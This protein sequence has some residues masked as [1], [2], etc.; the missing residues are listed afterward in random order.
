[1]S[2]LRRYGLLSVLGL[3]ALLWTLRHGGAPTPPKL[4]SPE[5]SKLLAWF[6]ALASVAVV[7]LAALGT[8]LP[9]RRWLPSQ[10]RLRRAALRLT[11]GLALLGTLLGAL[12]VAGLFTPRAVWATL[13]VLALAGG[14]VV[15]SHLAELARAPMPRDTRA[16]L[17]AVGA[18]L[19][20]ASLHAMLPQY[21]WDA[22][23]Y[24]LALP[25]AFLRA[26]RIALDP[27]SIFT[28][29]PLL[30]ESVYAAGIA[31]AG[32]AAAKLLHAQCLGLAA[33]LLADLARSR[34]PRLWPVAPL[35]LLADPT[36]LWEATVVYNDLTLVLFAVGSLDAL[37]ALDD[38][39]DP[40]ALARAGLFAGA[41]V[42]TRAP[43][44]LA[45]LCFALPA[46]LD[47]RTPL[48]R[49]GRLALSLAAGAALLLPW[50]ARNLLG[51]GGALGMRHM[52]P[53]FLEQMRAFR[54]HIGAG[55]GVTDLLLLPWRLFFVSTPG[56]YDGGFGFLLG[57]L[58]L[59]GAAALALHEVPR[60]PR[61]LWSSAL[62]FT[63]GWFA[64]VQEARF[65]LPLLPLLGLGAACGLEA[66]WDAT[67][68]AVRAAVGAAVLAAC[69]AVLAQASR[70]HRYTLPVALGRVSPARMARLDA[71][72]RVGDRLR[73]ELPAGAR[74]LPLFE[75][76]AWHLRGVDAPRFHLN[77]GAP[78]W[79]EVHDAVTRGDLCAWLA[80]ERFTHVLVNLT[81]YRS[82]PPVAVPSYHDAA[83]MADMAAVQR[84]LHA[85]GALWFRD[86]GI[87]VWR[88]GPGACATPAP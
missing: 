58:H 56:R 80:R 42:A 32:P 75:S 16:L 28:A 37:L 88:L 14:R 51:G 87:S 67:H 70:T 13:L 76:R 3:G 19:L 53:L 77:E 83:I 24:H 86:E 10:G 74:V 61:R 35:A 21:G 43:G 73:A 26:G 59:A 18:A 7:N 52:H 22:L 36:V 55:R 17:L 71:A 1:M 62:A 34:A 50:V 68:R 64:T 40:G 30:A 48:A 5:L 31:L 46:L 60:A 79:C 45:P 39:R 41:C 44:A 47:R 29:F 33:L 54:E 63:L 72:E 2:A 49:R 4:T 81:G 8:T 20:P 78:L 38:P 23:T 82:T 9:L 85:S 25:D 69:A 66:A 11:A 12:G 57:P 6:G 84:T 15:Q 65:L 27:R